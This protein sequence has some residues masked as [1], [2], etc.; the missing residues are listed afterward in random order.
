GARGLQGHTVDEGMNTVVTG[1][2]GVIRRH[3]SL[4]I[5]GREVHCAGVVCDCIAELILR[6]DRNVEGISCRARCR[7]G[8]LQLRRS[9]R[10]EGDVHCREAGNASGYCV[11]R[12]YCLAARG[13]QGHAV[14][15]G[16]DTVVT[17]YEGVICRH[18]SLS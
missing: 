6:C 10:C 11:R 7:R 18:R 4:P 9:T 12:R 15:E 16:M 13:L 14:D 5:T 1:Y 3:R 17:G 2:E 8:H